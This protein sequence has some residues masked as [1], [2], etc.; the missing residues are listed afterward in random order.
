VS[1]KEKLRL[2]LLLIGRGRHGEPCLTVNFDEG[3]VM[4]FKEVGSAD[5]LNGI[6]TRVWKILSGVLLSLGVGAQSYLAWIPCPRRH[7]TLIRR[8]L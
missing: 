4:L 2:Y 7:Q 1:R 8:G 5:Q 3:T 6:H